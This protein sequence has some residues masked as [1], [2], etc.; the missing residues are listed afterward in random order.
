MKFWEAMKLMEEG[1]NVR[2]KEWPKD[3]HVYWWKFAQNIQK[4]GYF[5]EWEEYV[6]PKTYSFED[7]ISLVNEGRLFRRK[8]WA[9][10]IV[11]RAIISGGY[12]IFFEGKPIH[13]ARQD[14]ETADWL[15]VIE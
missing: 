5:G 9:K 2:S 13:L 1:K 7:I 6:P 4:Y 8:N 15:E 11:F 14:I 10:G 12:S 3:E